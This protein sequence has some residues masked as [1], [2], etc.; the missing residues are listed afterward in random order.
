MATTSFED[1]DL[2]E[3]ERE[4]INHLQ[5]DIIPPTEQKDP[6]GGD[7]IDEQGG[8]ETGSMGDKRPNKLSDNLAKEYAEAYL[9]TYFTTLAMVCIVFIDKDGEEAQ[10]AISDDK[11]KLMVPLLALELKKWAAK[12]SNIEE[13]PSWIFLGALIIGNTYTTVNKAIVNNKEHKSI[14]TKTNKAK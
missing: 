2:Q 13:F 9:K 6:Y 11:I 3:D 7:D 4:L 1:I 14:D 5:Q 8:N 12:G 10:Y